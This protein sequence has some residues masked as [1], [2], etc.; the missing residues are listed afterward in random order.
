MK[1]GSL[2]VALLVTAVAACGGS[3][4]PSGSAT[5]G[6]TASGGAASSGGIAGGTSPVS[7]GMGGSGGSTSELPLILSFSATPA[8]LTTAG[9]ATL[10]WQVKNATALGIDR[11]IGPVTGTSVTATVDATTIFTLTASNAAGSTTAT[12]AVVVGSNPSSDK[13]G[14]YAAMVAP[15]SGESFLAP[16]SLRLVAAAH[17][18]NVY[19]NSPSDG[20]GGNAA[21]VQ[22]FVDDT[23]VLEVDGAHAEYWIFKGFTAGVA[24]GQH[25]VWARAIY[26]APDEV[27]DSP[28]ALVNVAATPTYA[29]VVDLT[30]DVVLDGATG[31]ELRGTADARIRLNGNGHRILSSS[32]ASGPLTLQF[33]DLFDLGPGDNLAQSA[34][35]VTTTG[36]ITVEDCRFDTSSTVR[37]GAAGGTAASIR[38]NL[39]RSN[40]RMPLGQNPGYYSDAGASYPVLGVTGG[41]GV[42]AGNNIGAGYIELNN[43][44]GW[45]VGGDTDADSNVLVGPRV[46]FSPTGT[47]QLRRNYSH[48]VYYGGWSQGCNFEL[49]GSASVVAEHNVVYGSSWP[50]RGVGGQFRYNLVLDAGHQWLWADTPGGNIH[51]NVFVGGDADVGGLYVLYQPTGVIIANNTID[52]LS[53]IG[54]AVKM[55]SGEVTLTSNLFY[56]VPTPGVSVEG[57][58]LNA[59]Y[60]LFFGPTT[61]YSDGRATPAH[62]LSA[63]PLLGEPP[64]TVFALDESGIWQRRTTVRDVLARYRARY[65]PK[66]GSPVIDAGDPAGGAGNDIGAVGAGTANAN[67]KF[68]TL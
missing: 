66:A 61:D 62:D 36:A 43:A 65:T 15:T 27:L 41:T 29:Q 17:D 16:A 38:S 64:T 39:F 49:G 55:T 42:F 3:G 67:D 58:T 48:H 53:D 50:V 56:R 40:M 34:T 44:K 63:D 45:T 47:V 24:A 14:R 10:T 21:K 4:K 32:G 25:R 59:D 52:G 5:G 31:Y 26:V 51:H 20:L 60:N 68:G 1:Q 54:L 18:P 46:G 33:V 23:V 57:G 7:G 13:S 22:F 19:T 8:S 12:T 30:T 9:G 28:P 6:V 2:G 11:G 37:L 35:D